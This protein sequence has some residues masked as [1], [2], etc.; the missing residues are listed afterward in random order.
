[1]TLLVD[2]LHKLA[3]PARLSRQT[4]QCRRVDW[5]RRTAN[6]PTLRSRSSAQCSDRIRV[7]LVIC[8]QQARQQASHRMQVCRI[9]ERPKTSMMMQRMATSE[10][11]SRRQDVPL[12]AC[13]V[14]EARML[15][16][17][18]VRNLF[19]QTCASNWIATAVD[20]ELRRK[21]R[22][23]PSST[24]GEVKLQTAAILLPCL[25]CHVHRQL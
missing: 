12:L 2:W 25:L 19:R 15:D 5:L 3:S 23:L 9:T 4:C 1:M 21:T 13:L 7:F 22:T 6:F 16:V 14:I 18:P 24:N 10:T 8:T 20:L 11:T 17:V